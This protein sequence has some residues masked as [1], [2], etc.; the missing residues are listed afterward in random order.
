MRLWQRSIQWQLA[1]AFGSV[2]R[3]VDALEEGIGVAVMTAAE[4]ADAQAGGQFQ[5]LA[6]QQQAFRCQFLAKVLGQI[7]RLGQG[8][9]RQQ[10]AERLATQAQQCVAITAKHLAHAFGEGAQAGIAT[11]V[12]VFV[13]DLLE[14][15]DIHQHQ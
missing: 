6:G 5:A 13:V 15:V 10:Y 14:E 7:T 12:A 4:T 2:E 3:T 1:L 9:A 11:G 8:G